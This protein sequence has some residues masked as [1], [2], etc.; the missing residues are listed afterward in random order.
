MAD[1]VNDLAERSGVSTDTARMG[2]GA[3]LAFLKGKI[4]EETFAM[5]FSAVPDACQA[6]DSA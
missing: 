5:V 4:P 2:L 3:V 6:M 1:L